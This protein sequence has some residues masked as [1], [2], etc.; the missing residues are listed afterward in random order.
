[1]SADVSAAVLHPFLEQPAKP[2]PKDEAATLAAA[3]V[4]PHCGATPEVSDTVSVR[5]GLICQR[6]TRILAMRIRAAA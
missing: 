1:M 3:Y 2:G 5:H 6:L 4:C